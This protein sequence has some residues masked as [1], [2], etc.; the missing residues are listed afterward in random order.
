MK[1]IFVALVGALTW[2]AEAW[3]VMVAVGV[4]HAEWL[5]MLPTLSYQSSLLVNLAVGL[6]IT[7]Y[8]IAKGLVDG[9]V[10]S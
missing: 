3:S 5:T 10:E 8:A 4:I 2:L 7:V 9:A 1:V 6:V